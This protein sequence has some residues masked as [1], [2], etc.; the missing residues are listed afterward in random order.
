MPSNSETPSQ[1]PPQII[2]PP[3]YTLD[4]PQQAAPSMPKITLAALPTLSVNPAQMLLSTASE[5]SVPLVPPA[6]GCASSV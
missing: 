4:A 6:P 2:P 1:Q 5:L 3:G